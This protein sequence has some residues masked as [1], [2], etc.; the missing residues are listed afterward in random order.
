MVDRNP[1][2]AAL[3]GSYL[4]PEIDRRVRAYR[5][6]NPDAAIISLGI[7]DTTEPLGL[8]PARAMEEKSKAMAT[9][10]GYSGYGSVQGLAP[11]RQAI[12]QRIYGGGVNPAD[13][14]ISDGAKCDIGRLQMLFG[15]A[16]TVAVQD[17]SY[18]A[19]V[20]SAVI[21]GQASSWDE[22]R[23]GYRKIV[24][25]PCKAE[26]NF[27]PFL[28]GLD[29]ASIDVI[30]FCSPNNP[31]GAV[32]THKQL[33]KLVAF[34]RQ[35][36][37]IIV[38]DAAYSAFI[39]D[40]S[41]P[42]TIYEIAGAADVAI[43]VGSFS[44]LAGFTGVRL[45]W[46]VVPSQLCYCDGSCVQ[47]DW[48]RLISTLFNG[49]SI[50][51]QCGAL[52]LLTEEGWEETNKLNSFYMENAAIL[53][54]AVSSAGLES[55]GGVDAPYLWVSFPGR[56]SWDIFD[57]LLTD[58]QLVVTPG[59]GFGPAGEGYIR[60]SAFAHRENILEAADRIKNRRLR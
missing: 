41:L 11:L 12:A 36:K 52:A 17:P 19:Y 2:L 39:Q 31:T 24:Y 54:Q 43:E 16:A 37:A 1:H 10:H 8:V 46:S 59:C 27:F 50:L 29:N 55:F 22:E 28:D 13:I 32:A 20:D 3:H 25:L 40:P 14:F 35:Q 38:F 30:Y 4:F 15:A 33:E 45:G 26:N 42:C 21:M 6:N 57:S 47:R 48:Y 49:A 9:H 58:A 7:G 5:E 60:L 53:Q 18:P 56:H 51:S 44:K 34:A 23:K